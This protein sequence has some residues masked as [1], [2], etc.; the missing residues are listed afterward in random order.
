MIAD[1]EFNFVDR[2]S[3]HWS[4]IQIFFRISF[5]D[6]ATFHSNGSLNKHKSLS[7]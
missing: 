1:R 3:V 7:Q 6:K 4:R 5:S 2:Y